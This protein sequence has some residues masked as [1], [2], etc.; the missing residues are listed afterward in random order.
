MASTAA[1][2]AAPPSAEHSSTAAA[3]GEP[4]AAAANVGAK[5]A[6]AAAAAAVPAAK[7]PLLEA[8]RRLKDQQ[9][10]MKAERQ[11]VAKDLKNA[12]KR[13][14]RLKRRARQLTDAD[15]LEVLQ[16]RGDAA[17]MALEGEPN[18]APTPVVAEPGSASAGRG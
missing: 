2:A 4:T 17:P 12:C 3:D 7:V 18:A 16:M 10:V 15:L 5:H 14:N 11:R 8:I 9:T 13:R 6:S 1:E